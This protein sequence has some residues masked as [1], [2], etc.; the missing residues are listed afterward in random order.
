MVGD[1]AVYL[2]ARCFGLW[3]RSRG[4]GGPSRIVLRPRRTS[5]G[6]ITMRAGPGTGGIVM[7]HW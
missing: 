1:D 7:Y 2:E 3:W 4:I 6:S 5:S